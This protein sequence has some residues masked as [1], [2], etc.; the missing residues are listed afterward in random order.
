ML[1]LGTLEHVYSI[2]GTTANYA[3]TAHSCCPALLHSLAVVL[4]RLFVRATPGVLP[5]DIQSEYQLT[6][7][8]NRSGDRYTIGE[9]I[10]RLILCDRGYNYAGSR[11]TG[12]MAD[13]AISRTSVRSNFVH[14]RVKATWLALGCLVFAG[15]A[16]S[17]DIEN[18]CRGKDTSCSGRWRS[19]YKNK[20][21]S[22]TSAYLFPFREA[23][24]DLVSLW[25]L[26]TED[27]QQLAG[28]HSRGLLEQSTRDRLRALCKLPDV[29]RRPELKRALLE[30]AIVVDCGD[31][32]PL[33]L[34]DPDRSDFDKFWHLTAAEQQAR[35]AASHAAI[36]LDGEY[37]AAVHEYI[38]HESLPDRNIRRRLLFIQRDEFMAWCS[39]DEGDYFS[40]PEDL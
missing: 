33:K 25:Q 36:P 11:T 15:V 28:M 40:L 17:G 7:P 20:K 37:V 13:V 29:V 39:G 2:L 23:G 6:V 31:S 18:I 14:R 24:N 35:M 9:V 3:D 21:H 12:H 38:C 4:S 5:G 1:L 32:T 26:T 19:Y 16:A 22:V 30:T 10:E 34:L 27:L 8:E